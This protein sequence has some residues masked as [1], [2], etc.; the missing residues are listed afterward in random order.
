MCDWSESPVRFGYFAT[1]ITI[2]I[3]INKN[4]DFKDNDF[5]K[6]VGAV[7]FIF[8][9]AINVATGAGIGALIERLSRKQIAI[10]GSRELFDASKTRLTYH[11]LNYLPGGTLWPKSFFKELPDTLVDID[12]NVYKLVALGGQVWMAED[13]KTTHYRDGSKISDGYDDLQG[14]ESQFS[15]SAVAGKRQICPA[16]WHIPSLKELASLFASPEI[17]GSLPGKTGIGVY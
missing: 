2:D 6:G 13:I 9:A 12:G 15:W 1:G 17:V 11:A 8:V 4:D 16:G 7:V 10:K 3:L 14:G 5:S